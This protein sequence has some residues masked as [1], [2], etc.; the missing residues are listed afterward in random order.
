MP[1]RACSLHSADTDP[2]LSYIA[3]S[4][5][6][7]Q[8]HHVA[9][10]AGATANTSRTSRESQDPSHPAGGGSRHLPDE[11]QQW[12]VTWDDIKLLHPIGRGSFGWVSDCC[13]RAS[14]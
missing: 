7:I 4:L 6:S 13:V 10:T 1:M 5:A 3:S 8:Q 12:E 11:M 9:S 14:R 2:L